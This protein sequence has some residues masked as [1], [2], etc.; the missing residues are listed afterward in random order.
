MSS[1]EEIRLPSSRVRGI[2]VF[3]DV[4]RCGTHRR[5]PLPAMRETVYGVEYSES[6]G[7][8]DVDLAP[9]G[10]WMRCFNELGSR[11]NASDSKS[12]RL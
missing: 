5:Y 9:Q 6:G 7:K 4:A 1:R 11:P 8:Y 10:K 3:D 2:L 12:Q